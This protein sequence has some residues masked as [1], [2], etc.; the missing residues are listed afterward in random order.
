[1]LRSWK[2]VASPH[3]SPKEAIHALL[4]ISI[5]LHKS[6]NFLKSAS[7]SKVQA[8]MGSRTSG[9][10]TLSRSLPRQRFLLLGKAQG[11]QVS[12]FEKTLLSVSSEDTTPFPPRRQ[13][14]KTPLHPLSMVLHWWLRA[15]VHQLSLK[16][17]RVDI[18]SC[19][20]HLVSVTT[21]QLGHCSG[22]VAT[23]LTWVG[24]A[25]FQ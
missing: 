19:T 13:Q 16:G 6:A 24:E 23:H 10:H 21:T 2:E 22:K 1:M 15:G 3:L 20:D 9:C 11:K 18:L 5:V 14:R 25:V 17:E 12:P 7:S 8:G 4:E